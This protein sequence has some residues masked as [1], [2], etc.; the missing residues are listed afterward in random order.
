MMH[1][2]QIA[3]SNESDR[4]AQSARSRSTGELVLLYD[5]QD[6]AWAS[7]IA[8]Q[9]SAVGIEVYH[10]LFDGQDLPSRSFWR[11]K[12]RRKRRYFR[13]FILVSSHLLPHYNSPRWD[14]LW[15]RT[16]FR[17]VNRVV[18]VYL[19]PIPLQDALGGNIPFLPRVE[20]FERNQEMARLALLEGMFGLN[21]L[22]AP[23]PFP[24][25]PISEFPAGE[26]NQQA[27]T[28]LHATLDIDVPLSLLDQVLVDIRSQLRLYSSDFKEPLKV[29]SGRVVVTRSLRDEMTAKLRGELSFYCEALA[30]LADLYGP[31]NW[32]FSDNPELDRARTRIDLLLDL[33]GL[34]DGWPRKLCSVVEN[35]YRDEADQ[36]QRE[37][38]L[39]VSSWSGSKAGIEGLERIMTDGQ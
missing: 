26:T 15:R 14:E 4:A 23:S 19:A 12:A 9:V 22:H 16:V 8:S 27:R 33:L 35:Y 7:W 17:Y 24:A 37:I 13:I 30:H 6:E 5:S 3:M 10:V 21:P 31:S 20:L 29:K 18:S 25:E 38:F 34:P 36:V 32:R 2:E 11:E 39:A 28:Y 1:P